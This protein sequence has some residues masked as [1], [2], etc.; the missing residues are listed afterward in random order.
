MAGTYTNILCHIIFSTKNR[1]ASINAGFASE[2]Y[3]YAG[4]IIR[5]EKGKLLAAGGTENH[6]HLL[7]VL[8]ASMSLSELMRKVKGNSSAWINK[9]RKVPGHFAW[10]TGYGAFSVSES[11]K[12]DVM[13]YIARQCEHHRHRSF[14]EEFVEFLEKH[15][16]DYDPRLI[17]D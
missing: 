17:W 12:K 1:E 8:P 6:L 7:S 9:N 5:D 13:H 4:G 14:E 16:V 2:L 15:N 3:A 10:Q 11:A